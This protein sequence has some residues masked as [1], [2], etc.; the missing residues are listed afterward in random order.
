MEKGS[1]TWDFTYNADALRTKRTNGTLTY[2]YVYYGGQL[3]YIMV[4]DTDAQSPTKGNHHFI[5]SYTPEGI[6]MGITY[7]GTA[8]YYLTNLQGDVVAILNNQGQRII[9]YTYDAWGNL[10]STVVHVA[11]NDEDYAE[12]NAKYSTIAVF[13]PL[14][15]RG[16][17]YDQETGLYYLQSRYYNPEIGRFINADKQINDDILGNNLFPYCGNSPIT[18]VDNSGKAWWIA[19]SAIVGGLIGAAGKIISNVSTGKDWKN[20]VW[21]A[22][23]GGTVFGAMIA[24]TGNVPL[25]GFASAAAESETN[26]IISYTSLAKSN[27]SEKRTPTVPNIAESVASIITDTA[28]NGISITIT[29]MVAGVIS[30][31]NNGWFQPKEFVSSFFGK[32][33]IKSQIQTAVQTG[34][35]VGIELVKSGMNAIFPQIQNLVSEIFP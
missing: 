10:L 27:G 22:A 2:D 11:E 3:M 18:R 6:P 25:A 7:Q 1:T 17:V 21:G 9:S 20:G 24:A 8:Y 16:Y 30:P 26:E 5:L 15:Y 13:N 28:I 34:M 23:V 4:K 35:L 33:A 32:Y 12:K 19:A 14:R 29:G 31:T